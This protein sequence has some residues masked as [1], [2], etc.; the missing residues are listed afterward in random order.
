MKSV[1]VGLALFALALG[2]MILDPSN[3]ILGF[4]VGLL[5]ALIVHWGSI[6]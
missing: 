4:G 5:A 6:A 1:V 3:V 2:I